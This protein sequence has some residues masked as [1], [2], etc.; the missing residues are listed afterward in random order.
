[1][2]HV[3]LLDQLALLFAVAVL[4]S[5][6][7]ARLR[8]PSTAGLLVAGALAGPSG[9]GLASRVEEIHLLAEVGVVLLLF[10]I[11][12]EL[13]LERLRSIARLLVIGGTLQV[14]LTLLAVTGGAVLLGMDAPAAIALGMAAALSSTALVLATLKERG[15]LDAPHGRFVVG[16]LVFQD[17]LVVPMVLLVPLLGGPLDALAAPLT[18]AMGKAAAMIVG[19]VLVSRVLVPRLM[20]WIEA[21]RSREVFLLAVVALC[22]GTA[23]L[24]ALAGLSLALGAFLG[25]LVIASTE[26]K[27]RAMGEMLPLRE[28]FTALFF[29]SLGM[30]FDVRVLV[31]EPLTVLGLVLAF[32]VL[33]GVIATAAAL[34]MRFPARASWLA[35]VALAQFGEFGFVLLSSARREALIDPATESA[36][37]AAGVASMFLTPLLIRIAPHLRAGEAL[38]RPLE[39]LLGAGPGASAESAPPARDHVVVAGLGVAGRLLL[40]GLEEL[41]VGFVAL[42]LVAERVSELRARHPHVHYADVT[43]EEAL[44]HAHVEHA[45]AVVIAINDPEAVQRALAVVRR[46]NPTV[47]IWV[48]TRY[49]AEQ[50]QLVALGATEVVC[51]EIES[52]SR[53]LALVLGASGAADEAVT[54]YQERAR[55][56]VRRSLVPSPPGA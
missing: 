25:G 37:I 3:P 46:V 14:G 17:L 47:P 29:V 55:E 45:R 50:P 33:K 56:V 28:L 16:V 36:V 34:A 10:S 21:T 27:H 32:T 13:S 19:V 52:A 42:D 44:H 24:T 31:A 22:M 30:L 43:S 4:V 1:M 12:M 18:V 54:R 35:G 20:R 5:I 26:F 39:R 38:L 49:A 9:L 41:G 7:A 2:A 40:E 15:E 53:L 23:W 11:G 6:V 48:R 8:L 51:E